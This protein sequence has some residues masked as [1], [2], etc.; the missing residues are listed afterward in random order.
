VTAAEEFANYPGNVA[1]PEAKGKNR[2]TAYGLDEN[3]YG[4]YEADQNQYKDYG[5]QR[6]DSYGNASASGANHVVWQ[7]PTEEA[8]AAH[9]Q[10]EQQK[11]DPRYQSEQ[12]H[13]YEYEQQRQMD[14]EAAA[15]R[16]TQAA[17][18]E[19]VITPIVGHPNGN[20]DSAPATASS[21]EPLSVHR[22]IPTGDTNETSTFNT[23]SPTIPQ[24]S[25]PLGAPLDLAPPIDERANAPSPSELSD[26]AP[27][28]AAFMDNSR[29]QTPQEGFYTPMDQLDANPIDQLERLEQMEKD[30]VIPPTT[31]DSEATNAPPPPPPP[32][33]INVPT[34]RESPVPMTPSSPASTSMFGGN[35]SRTTASN[36]GGGKISAAAFRRGAKPRMSGDDEESRSARRLP[37]PPTI[38]QTLPS[39]ET[40]QVHAGQG[41]ETEEGHGAYVDTRR[42]SD[43]PPVYAGESLR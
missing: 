37:V 24:T 41:G 4:G 26:L 2:D 40:E 23:Q 32:M 22:A 1:S 6:M 42:E 28:H 13:D 16:G 20:G 31:N 15:W 8:L 36:S 38:V 9:G 17:Q 12:G 10:R 33:P 7:G 29:T 43:P 14:A 35:S 27:P 34:G 30:Y 19:Q 21:W 3:P 18:P 25:E 5:G 11:S 39:G